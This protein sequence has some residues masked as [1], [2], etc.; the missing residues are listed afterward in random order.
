MRRRSRAGGRAAKTRRGRTATLKRGNAPKAV[1]RRVSST[2]SQQTK[3]TRLIRERD[4]ALERQ[5]AT[6]NE[7]ARL[8]GELRESLEQHTVAGDVL[9]LIAGQHST[10]RRCSRRWSSSAAL[11]CQADKGVILRPSGK[12][13]SY[14]AAASYQQN[15]QYVEHLKI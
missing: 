9:N 7:N 14:Y 10:C 5:A 6:A 2:T 12:E 8:L 4:E 11:L 13:A 15:P 1:R 3:L